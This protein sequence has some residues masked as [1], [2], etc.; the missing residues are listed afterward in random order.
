M[1]A[2]TAAQVRDRRPG[3]EGFRVL[4]D[5]GP[6]LLADAV[7]LDCDF[8]VHPRYVAPGWQLHVLGHVH[9]PEK[10][11]EPGEIPEGASGGLDLATSD[12]VNYLH[13]LVILLR[14]DLEEARGARGRLD[15]DSAGREFE[16]GK[17]FAFVEVLSLVH[18]QT[19]AFGVPLDEI[20][21]AEF[22]EDRE[23]T[24]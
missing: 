20:G 6:R 14:E 8:F 22:D 9:T 10:A 11:L 18:H 13:D 1:A 19:E 3:R 2:A 23:L 21:L 7:V 17:A 4:D 16:A 15:R 12:V 5:L 24:G